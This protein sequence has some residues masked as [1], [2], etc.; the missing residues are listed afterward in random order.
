MQVTQVMEEEEEDSMGKEEILQEE[1]TMQEAHPLLCG[2]EVDIGS[3]SS[4][5]PV[6][7]SSDSD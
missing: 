3:N 5:S 6:M 1:E 7:D 2:E 4:A